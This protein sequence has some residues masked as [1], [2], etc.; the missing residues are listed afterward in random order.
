MAGLDAHR[1]VN[2]GDMLPQRLPRG[3][4]LLTGGADDARMLD[5]TRLDMVAH[6]ALMFT[7]KDGRWVL[8]RSRSHT[9]KVTVL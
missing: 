7:K 8:L 6:V 1:L 4:D 2:P 5:V 9:F 3:T